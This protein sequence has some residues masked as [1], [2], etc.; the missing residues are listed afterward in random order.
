MVGTAESGP[1]QVRG[2]SLAVALGL[3][4]WLMLGA[5]VVAVVVVTT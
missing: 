2:V 1:A 3:V 5:V 4:G